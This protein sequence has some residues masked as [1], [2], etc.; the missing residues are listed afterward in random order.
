M[1]DELCVAGRSV[2]NPPLVGPLFGL[3][4]AP[5]RLEEIRGIDE[6]EKDEE[7]K[8]SALF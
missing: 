3:P 6:E 8:G 4:R 1:T 7:D 5:V 2:K